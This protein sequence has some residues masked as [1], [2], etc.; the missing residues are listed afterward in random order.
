MNTHETE[1]KTGLVLVQSVAA[2]PALAGDGASAPFSGDNAKPKRTLGLKIFD[3]GLYG[4]LTNTSVFAVS[5]L[6]TYMTKM[7]HEMGE[8]GST[9]R[10]V[11]TWVHDRKK[12]LI[13]GFNKIGVK[14]ESAEMGAMVFFSF[15]DGTLFAPLVKLLEDRREAIA[16]KIDTVLGTKAENMKAYEA[17]PKQSWTSVIWGRIKTSMIVLPVAI[18]MDKIGGNQKLFYGQGHALADAIE[19][20]APKLANWLENHS[21]RD[22]KQ[23]FAITVFEAFYTSVCT[24]GLY[25]L[26]RG[27][28]RKHPPQSKLAASQDSVK[29]LPAVEERPSHERTP[30]R[31]EQ[32][33]IAADKPQTSVMQAAHMERLVNTPRMAEV[34]A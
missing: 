28:A 7:G 9:L 8:V 14:G 21:V 25:V 33:V 10:K 4:V 30:A 24:I 18:V 34:T 19:T 5:V 20:K 17:E 32:P 3:I 6:L 12:P 26:S 1:Q 13:K 11:G 29:A 27:F 22:R 16:L 2:A 15:L 31:D 23:F